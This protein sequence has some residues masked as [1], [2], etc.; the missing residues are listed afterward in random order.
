MNKVLVVGGTFDDNGGKPSKVVASVISVLTSKFTEVK[1]YNGGYFSDIENILEEVKD[2][3]FVL[4]WANVPNDKPKIRDVKSVNPKTILVTSKR[5]T[6]GKY[7]FQELIN[8][9]LGQKANLCVEFVLSEKGYGFRLFDPLG[10][11]WYEGDD[12]S[13]LTEEM[14]ERMKFL[15]TITRQNTKQSKETI[16]VPNKPKFFNLIKGYADTFH[17]LII[18]DET[19][20]RFLGNSSFRCTKGGFPSFKVNDE[21][22]FVSKR[23]V[24]KRFIDKSGFVPVLFTKDEEIYYCGENKPSVDTPIQ[25]RLYRALPKIN[26]MIHSHTYIEDAPFTANM[27]PCGGLEEVDEVLNAIGDNRNKDFYAVNLIGHGSIVMSS[28]IE[29]LTNIQYVGRTMPECIKF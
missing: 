23:N 27:I 14:S 4:W 8:R 6:E 11:L 24:D 18:P 12:I 22:Y 7:S 21:L 16:E 25:V 2:A 5:N 9:A 17:D 1:S 28:T 13:S 3:D 20:T 26:Y 10:D 19:V 15:Q 29:K